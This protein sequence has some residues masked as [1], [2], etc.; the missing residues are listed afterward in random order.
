MTL[1]YNKYT[2]M[3]QINRL[4][5]SYH[6]ST[7][8]SDSEDLNGYNMYDLQWSKKR[9]SLID[10]SELDTCNVN[11]YYGTLSYVNLYYRYIYRQVTPIA[12]LKYHLITDLFVQIF[13]NDFAL[14]LETKQYNIFNHV[15]KHFCDLLFDRFYLLPLSFMFSAS[16]FSQ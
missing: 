7:F 11:L 3:E 5:N 10:G 16:F 8:S 12:P 4:S 2:H 13:E 9:I 6:Y 14:I 1:L 15:L